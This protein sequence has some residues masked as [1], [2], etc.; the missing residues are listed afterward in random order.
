MVAPRSSSLAILIGSAVLSLAAAGCGSDADDSDYMLLRVA[1]ASI[2]KDASCYEDGE[3]P[4][5]VKD[6]TTS[7]F[8]GGTLVVFNGPDEAYYLESETTALEGTRDGDVLTFTAKSVDVEYVNGKPGKSIRD[9]DHDGL[10]DDVKDGMVDADKDGLDDS[11]QD[12]EVDTDGD[13]QDDRYGD[14]EVDVNKDDLDDR[15]TMIE[16]PT[17][18]DK[19][20]K[21]TKSTVSITISDSDITGKGETSSK[22]TCSGATCP[23]ELPSCKS[24]VTFVGTIV[25]EA[26]VEHQ[27]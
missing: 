23:E 12:D 16:P 4:T 24:S 19:V 7:F 2:E 20:T 26:S 17:E 27:I 18:G 8:A 9:A 10:E 25:E 13:G 3:V 14:E 1:Y 22:S 6:D 11:Y 5:E 21:T 15:F